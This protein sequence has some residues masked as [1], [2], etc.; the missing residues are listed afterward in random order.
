MKYLENTKLVILVSLLLS[1]FF[2]DI[3]TFLKDYLIYVLIFMLTISIKKVGDV[4]LKKEKRD[5]VSELVVLNLFGLGG[6][7]IL[8]SYLFIG[9]DLYRDAM[10]IFALMPPAAGIVSLG[11]LYN[12]DMKVDLYAEFI[13]YALSL[14]TIPLGSFL[15]LNDVISPMEI[16]EVIFLIL[17]IPFILSRGVNK[18]DVSDSVLKS[19]VNLSIGVIVFTIVGF[20]LE[21]MIVN[22]SDIISLIFILIVLRLVMIVVLFLWSRKYFDE[23][24]TMLITLFGSL[25]NGS[26]ATAIALLTL[27]VEST[28]PLAI[29]VIFFSLAILL[30]DWLH[31]RF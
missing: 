19:L 18:L 28:P 15:F 5:F 13:A 22:F 6:L 31:E 16:V 11:Y 30:L 2:Q 8:F 3:A 29:E 7:Y 21:E 26:A 14:I 9:N 17:I 4:K 24:K 1:I 20:N 25:K 12:V 27:G 10:I 23:S